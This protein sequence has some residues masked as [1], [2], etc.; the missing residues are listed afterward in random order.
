MANT[1]AGELAEK[2]LLPENKNVRKYVPKWI[3]ESSAWAI[4]QLMDAEKPIT[5]ENSN[6]M[7]L[8]YLL[9][10]I[11]PNLHHFQKMPNPSSSVTLEEYNRGIAKYMMENSQVEWPEQKGVQYDKESYAEVCEILNRIIREDAQKQF[12]ISKQKKK[13][14]EKILYAY[15]DNSNAEKSCAYGDNSNATN[16]GPCISGECKKG[17]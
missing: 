17:G 5:A 11:C 15:G 8:R 6:A 1:R 3:V 13:S 9:N 12:N 7:Q 4:K 16:E 2:L 10:H 14:S